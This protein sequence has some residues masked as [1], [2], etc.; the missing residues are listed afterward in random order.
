[1]T[2]LEAK[3]PDANKR[4][5][6]DVR[7]FG[8]EEMRRDWHYPIGKVVRAP[9]HTGF[10][11]ECTQ[12]GETKRGYPPLPR[13]D[14]LEVADG[15]VIWTARA[16]ASASLPS[17]QSVSWLVDPTTA[18][19]LTVASTVIDGGIVYPVLSGGEDAVTYSLTAQLTWSNG[20]RDDVTVEIP[21]A[22]Q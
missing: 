21:V 6:I 11:Y 9:W 8:Y 20:Q 12:D 3:D 19:P 22:Q 4:Y 13:E 18:A 15:S 5:A 7:L 10:Y 2:T 17:I 1:M 14:G 16:P